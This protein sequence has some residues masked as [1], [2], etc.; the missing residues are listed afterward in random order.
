MSSYHGDNTDEHTLH[1]TNLDKASVGKSFLQ[2][3]EESVSI[4]DVC[5][6]A[7]E[8]MRGAKYSCQG[9]ILGDY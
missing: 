6:N 8:I 5:S 4:T 9:H 7:E 1:I 3:D 2:K